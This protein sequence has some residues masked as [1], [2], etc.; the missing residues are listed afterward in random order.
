MNTSPSDAACGPSTATTSAWSSTSTTPPAPASCTSR[1]AT[2]APPNARFD[3]EQLVVIDHPD[4]VE[5][6]SA[7]LQTL[8]TRRTAVEQ[9]EGRWRDLLAARGVEPGDASLLVRATHTAIDAAIHTFAADPPQWLTDWIG[10][11]PTT[12]AAAAVWDD[13]VGRIARHRC[14]HGVADNEPGIGPAPT[15]VGRQSPMAATHAAAPRRPPLAGSPSRARPS[16]HSQRGRQPS[17]STVSSNSD[18]SSTKHHRT[19]GQFI[20]R[21]VTS[22]LDAQEVHEYLSSAMAAQGQRREWII[23]N[24]PHLIELE[25]VTALIAQQEPLAHWPA[26]QS[27]NVRR[28]LEQ[29]HALAVPPVEREERTLAEIDR[30]ESDERSRPTARVAARPPPPA[31]P[32]HRDRR[33]A[34]RSQQPSWI[35]SVSQLRTARRQARSEAAFAR[36]GASTWDQARAARRAT[37]G[38]DVLCDPP[39]WVLDR[40]LHLDEREALSA[41]EPTRLADEIVGGA[42][43]RD[44]RGSPIPVRPERAV[45]LHVSAA[46]PGVTS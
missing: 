39:E 1:T 24:W 6:T 20:E 45:D 2:G 33:R 17:W 31:S 15:D 9:A 32:P 29:L 3:W 18:S 37:V 12:A 42:L 10:A 13:A 22:Q 5:V 14:V 16:S 21:I 25:Q 27:P 41:T 46:V 43:D 4:P 7:G 35:T 30:L 19:N 23:A 28:M 8:A 38:H 36:Y 44:H 34:R 11:R 40:L 26:N